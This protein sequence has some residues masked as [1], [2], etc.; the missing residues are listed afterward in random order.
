MDHYLS[1]GKLQE[2]LKK[3][4]ALYRRAVTLRAAAD[5]MIAK[6]ETLPFPFTR[7]LPDL[8]TGFPIRNILHCG[9]GYA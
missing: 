9:M 5:S 4:Y 6:G 3:H 7:P 2:Y 8:Q 1:A